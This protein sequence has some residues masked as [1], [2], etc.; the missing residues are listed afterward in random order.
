[1]AVLT[2]SGGAQL[3]TN[4]GKVLVRDT[5]SI[6]QIVQ[7]TTQTP[8]S[9]SS[10]TF[11]ST[12][13]AASITPLENTNK[14]LVF[15]NINGTSSNNGHTITTVFRNETNLGDVNWG[16]ASFFT[17]LQTQGKHSFQY[18]DSP[19]TTSA[20]EYKVYFRILDDSKGAGDVAT[21]GLNVITLMEVSQ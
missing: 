13:L 6:L 9:T 7:G 17:G 11:V 1:M 20:I 19:S 21:R 2:N 12:N 10:M 3:T 16:F 4:A 5:G 14:I 18:L 15:V 8:T